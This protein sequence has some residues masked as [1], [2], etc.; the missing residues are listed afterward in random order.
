MM[1][2]MFSSF[3]PNLPAFL[4]GM[5]ISFSN[6]VSKRGSKRIWVGFVSLAVNIT[7][8]KTSLWDVATKKQSGF[9]L[10]VYRRN[11]SS[12]PA[13]TRDFFRLLPDSAHSFFVS[14]FGF[15]RD[16]NFLVRPV[17]FCIRPVIPIA[18]GGA[19]HFPATTGAWLNW[20]LIY[21]LFRFV[22][23]ARTLFGA[24]KWPVWEYPVFRNLSGLFT[25]V[26]GNALFDCHI[27]GACPLLTR[28]I[29]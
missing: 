8:M 2:R 10:S 7:M 20:D 12:A 16:G 9:A 4:A 21:L 19:Y 18:I 17:F 29:V 24:C 26:P 3:T 14:S 27:N 11:E 25:L 15:G 13:R 28:S 22:V 23:I 6:R 1:N 5:A